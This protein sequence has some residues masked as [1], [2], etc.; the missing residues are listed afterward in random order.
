MI[1][2]LSTSAWLK[3]STFKINLFMDNYHTI[4]HTHSKYIARW[5]SVNWYNPSFRTLL[6]SP[7]V[8]HQ[9]CA[10]LQPWATTYPP[11]AYINLFL[12]EI[13]CKWTHAICSL[14]ECGCFQLA[15]QLWVS[16]MLLHVPY[17]IPERMC[18]LP[19]QIPRAET[20]KASTGCPA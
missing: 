2:G 3:F 15:P 17:F 6:S 13:S 16:A 18:P 12:T 9:S 8:C 5:L 1:T 19:Q 7:N 14:V 10:H 20:S 4:K 11:S